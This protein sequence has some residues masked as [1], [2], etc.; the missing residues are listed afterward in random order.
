MIDDH[1]FCQCMF[2]LLSAQAGTSE[3]YNVKVVCIHCYDITGGALLW[4][5]VFFR[6]GFAAE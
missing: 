3:Y 6:S 1:E 5:L 2:G 4:L